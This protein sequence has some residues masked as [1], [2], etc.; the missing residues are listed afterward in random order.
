MDVFLCSYEEVFSD[1]S[2]NIALSLTGQLRDVHIPLQ[3]RVRHS[4][5]KP[6]TFLIIVVM[7]YVVEKEALG[8]RVVFVILKQVQTV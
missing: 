6:V 4:N 1:R 7:Y 3:V 5:F 8:L 2:F